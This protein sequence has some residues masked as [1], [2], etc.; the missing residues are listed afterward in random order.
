[1]CIVCGWVLG[2][3]GK[4]INY[5]RRCTRGAPT[6]NGRKRQDARWRRWIG[7]GNYARYVTMC[8]RARQARE[9]RNYVGGRAVKHA[10][11]NIIC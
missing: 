11:D 7:K 2:L 9:K 5:E 8:G 3:E 4:R 10:K 1:M 6:V